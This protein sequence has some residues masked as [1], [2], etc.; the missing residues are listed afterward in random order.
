VTGLD[1]SV[2]FN[3]YSLKTNIQLKLLK[4]SVIHLSR[5][6]YVGVIGRVTEVNVVK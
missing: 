4:F 5:D 1:V 2:R 6:R 3:L